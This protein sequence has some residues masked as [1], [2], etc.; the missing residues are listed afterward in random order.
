MQKFL[1]L[2]YSSREDSSQPASLDPKYNFHSL[3]SWSLEIE[4]GA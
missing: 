4:F 1:S 3:E 2:L